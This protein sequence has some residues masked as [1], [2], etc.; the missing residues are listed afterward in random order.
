MNSVTKLLE[1]TVL[2]PP[3][4]DLAEGPVWDHR[5]GHLMWVD[6]FNGDLFEGQRNGLV[7]SRNSLG[8]FVGAVAPRK[9]K[10]GFAVACKD[11]FGIWD[12]GRLELLDPV[13]A[14]TDHRM[15]DGKCD[16][17]GRLWAGSTHLQHDPTVGAL[18]RWD[19][20]KP[21]EVMADGLTLPN[22]L[23]WSPDDT[24]MYLVES[25]AGKILV[26][27]FDPE[28]GKIGEFETLVYIEGLIPDGLSI[29][30]EGCIWVAI[31]GNSEVRRYSASGDLISV[32]PMP[33]TQ[34]SSCAFSPDGTLFITS[35]RADLSAQDL[36]N[37]PH[38]GSVFSLT[39]NT[40]GVPVHPFA[41]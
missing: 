15:S 39:T 17:R 18:H 38:A 32:V 22:G 40:R 23:G 3:D 27:E 10:S 31:W 34:P 14:G 37:Q 1:P 20:T 9:S 5:T 21:S 35:A 16:S 33:V 13:L 11:G 29:D 24:K 8:T 26:T 41:N 19:G 12:G 2:F 25:L 28:S 6:L 30:I 36:L 4:A 7:K